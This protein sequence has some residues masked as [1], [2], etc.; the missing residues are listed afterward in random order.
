MDKI[1][2]VYDSYF[3]EFH[4]R[5]CVPRQAPVCI[6]RPRPIKELIKLESKIVDRQFLES[7]IDPIRS[8]LNIF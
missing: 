2:G 1:L 7:Q 3:C 6:G 8:D 5:V 4:W